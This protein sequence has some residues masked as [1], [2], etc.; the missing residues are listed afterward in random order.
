MFYPNTS[1][2]GFSNHV[3]I[4]MTYSYSQ[5]RITYTPTTV[6]QLVLQNNKSCDITKQDMPKLEHLLI[7]YTHKPNNSHLEISSL[8][9]LCLIRIANLPIH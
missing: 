3:P 2:L 6:M 1:H 9:D 7:Y 4:P 8:M 5:L